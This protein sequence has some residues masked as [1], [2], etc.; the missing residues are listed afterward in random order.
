MLAW[1]TGAE[2]EQAAAIL[3]NIERDVAILR[4]AID[5]MR[6]HGRTGFARVTIL[7]DAIE[8][9]AAWDDEGPAEVAIDDGLDPVRIMLQPTA[10]HRFGSNCR[11]RTFQLPR[12]QSLRAQSVTVSAAGRILCA[13]QA[14]GRENAVLTQPGRI[15]PLSSA[16][17]G[18]TIV[19]PVYGDY[20]ATRACLES[21]FA[22]L[23]DETNCRAVIVD[24]ASPDPRIVEFLADAATRSQA[25]LF[26]NS[27]NLGF[28]G[29]VNRALREIPHGD[30]ILL[31]ADTIVPMGFVGRLSAA[32]RSST[33]IGIVMPLSNNGDLASFPTPFAASSVGSL[34]DVKRIDQIAAL[35]N[36]GEVVDIP[37]A[38]GFCLYITRACINAVGLLSEDFDRG[39]LEDVD[40]CLRARERGFRVVCAPSVYVGHAGSRSFG[41]EKRS[42]VV[43]NLAVLRARR[44]GYELEFAA[45]AAADPLRK[46][47]QA[48]EQRAAARRGPTRL[49]VAGSGVVGAVARSRG[50]Q[51]AATGEAIL[52]LEVRRSS[53]GSQAT[54]S[55]P[56]GG[57]PLSAHFDFSD[58]DQCEAIITFI[59]QINVSRIEIFDPINLPL[60]FV[61]LLLEID[62]PYDMVLADAGLLGRSGAAALLAANRRVRTLDE[63]WVERWRSI[64]AGAQAILAPDARARSFATR[65][66]PRHKVQSIFEAAPSRAQG[67]KIAGKRL[68]LLP[69][70]PCA[71]EQRLMSEIARA[72]LRAQPETNILVVGAT[73]D[74]EALMRIGNVHVTGP[75]NNVELERVLFS[76]GVGFLFANVTQPLFGH[77]LL[78]AA[79][80]CPQPMAYFDWSAGGDR[81][82]QRDLPLDPRLPLQAIAAELR[83]WSEGRRLSSRRH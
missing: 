29:A 42:L 48:I 60:R 58:S 57:D 19:V 30:V 59:R 47:R 51:L 34:E 63:A 25:A 13:V 80:N 15:L 78:A 21:L 1:A 8:G 38:I 20:E 77:P 14:A 73:L 23:E 28:V 18:A 4:Q 17:D 27:R 12:P 69:V 82:R 65:L 83:N 6:S 76:Y 79:F 32:A 5:V 62:V 33:D 22:A 53:N 70:R 71:D 46:F 66:L 67:S 56:S 40:Y 31:N 35:V 49:L 3:V 75:V 44:P 2:Q 52:T 61:E 11:G 39:Y 55:D 16:V 74:D 36:A 81:P 72:Y 54:F 37:N 10:S 9:W 41:K 68:A 45:F 64:A 43:R 24:D 26:T 50:R 7:N